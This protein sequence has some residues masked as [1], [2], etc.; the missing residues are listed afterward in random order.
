MLGLFDNIMC[1]AASVVIISWD[2]ISGDVRQ[3]TE[4]G[5]VNISF[6]ILTL[7]CAIKMMCLSFSV[8][9]FS[10]VTPVCR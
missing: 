5:C 10:T 1:E 4:R 3:D 9:I 6:I 7:V 2:Q 8:D